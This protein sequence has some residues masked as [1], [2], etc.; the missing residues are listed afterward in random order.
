MDLQEGSLASLVFPD[1]EPN[2]LVCKLFT[3]HTLLALQYLAGNRIIHRDV[4]P[5]N[6]LYTMRNGEPHFQLADFGSSM[7]QAERNDH[8]G[9]PV[10]AAPEIYYRMEQTPEADVWSLFVTMAEVLNVNEFRR[11]RQL[12]T[13]LFL[14]N[15]NGIEK[16]ETVKQAVWEVAC[17][18]KLADIQDM[19]HDQAEKRPSAAELLIRLAGQ[20]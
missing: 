11:T 4:K 5:D 1:P 18:P 13:E 3:K 19:A 15:T 20:L 12:L 6:I 9:T 14:W 2:P 17:T 8:C 7:D 10:Y 16:Y